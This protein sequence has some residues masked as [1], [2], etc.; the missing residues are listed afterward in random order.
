[1]QTMKPFWQPRKYE[2]S[3]A[4]IKTAEPE[5]PYPPQELCG[6]SQLTK[7]NA[8]KGMG[9]WEKAFHAANCF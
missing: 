7:K 1:M 4:E 5:Q 9:K 8:G 6:I 3:D 2:G